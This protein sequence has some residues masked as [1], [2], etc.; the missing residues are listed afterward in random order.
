MLNKL[1]EELKEARINSE[2]TLQQLSSKTRIDL[3]FLDA[4]ETGNF[5]FLPELYVKAFLKEYA[6]FVGLNE[7]NILKKYEAA[8]H[9]KEY[10]EKTEP[11]E[12]V[13][14]SIEQHKKEEKPAIKYTRPLQT[15][16]SETPAA[17]SD[18]NKDA[19]NRRRFILG[20]LIGGTIIIIALVY[21][22]FFNDSREIIVP[23][24]PIDEVIEDNTQRYVEEE[25]PDES[26]ASA[27]DSL[28]LNIRTT[29][30]S[31]VKIILDDVRTE[32]FILF[33]N[34][35]KKLTTGNN[36]KITFGNSYAVKL[37]L[38]EKPLNFT[39]GTGKVAHV[40]I[41][42]NGLTNLETPSGSAQE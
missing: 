27:A 24:K 20:A 1:G 19:Q 2:L 29:D 14:E 28:H 42:S 38:N 8:K 34:S 30:T 39:P 7:V 32:E 3:K 15:Y 33:P 12:P 37:T 31:W 41:N 18:D 17:V 11:A 22:L 36:Y 40:L 16:E 25:T 26:F 10:E 4:M 13:K 21:F 9:G 6:K 23:E 35:Q 5:S